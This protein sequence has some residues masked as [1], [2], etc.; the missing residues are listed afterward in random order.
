M[1][2]GILLLDKEEG[3]TSRKVDNL[4]AK[5]FLNKKVGHLGTLDPFA[6]GLLLVA[7]GKA[8]KFL[9]YLDSSFKTYIAKLVLG[10]KTDTGDLTGNFIEE[11]EI[12]SLDKALIERVF[13]GFLGMSYQLPPM[14]SAIKID[15]VPLYKLAH[16]GKIKEREKRQIEIKELSCLEFGENYIVF[17]AQVS[18]G[19]YIRTLGEDIA[20]KLGSVG[21]LESLRRVEI[22]S[23]PVS[24][25]KKLDELAEGDFLSPSPF[26]NLEKIPLSDKQ[27]A[28]VKNG[29]KILLPQAIGDEVALMDKEEAI[30][31]Y[32]REEGSLYASKRGL[33]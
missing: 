15:G 24:R 2:D 3:M 26:V 1:K 12:Q 30:A 21:Y 7:V 31:V 22:G 25:A 9:P 29:R 16:K 23:I 33:F 27:I 5:K 10:K 14:T 13:A 28:D 32:T 18:S 19:T 6:T 11:K 4:I 20:E 17:K 8:T